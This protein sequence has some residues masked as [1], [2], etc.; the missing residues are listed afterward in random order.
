M[1]GLGQDPYERRCYHRD[2]FHRA[3]NEFRHFFRC[4]H[5]DLLRDKLSENQS[6]ECDDDH[7][8][9]LG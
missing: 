9:T 6:K 8:Y 7:Y 1:G 5:T 3:G 2:E 4:A